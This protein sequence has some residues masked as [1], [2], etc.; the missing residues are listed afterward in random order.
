MTPPWTRSSPVSGDAS[1]SSGLGRAACRISGDAATARRRPQGVA[2]RRQEIEHLIAMMN[3]VPRLSSTE[4]A[5]SSPPGA[6]AAP[7]AG[8]SADWRSSCPG[9]SSSWR[10]PRCSSAA[11]P[12]RHRAAGVG[13][14]ARR[15]RRRGPRRRQAW[16]SPLGV[17]G[18][19]QAPGAS[20]DRLRR[21]GRRRDGAGRRPGSCSSCSHAA[22]S[23]W[24]GPA[25]LRGLAA[26]ARPVVLA[27]ASVTRGLLALCWTALKVGALSYGGGFG[28]DPARRAGGR[29]PTATPDDALESLN[30]VALGQGHA[31]PRRAH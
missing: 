26:H 12:R 10:S 18:G 20:A 11:P 17:G 25:R 30:A 27:G 4:L 2:R 16:N 29:G 23:S 3:L 31:R 1:A 28:D 6:C 13:A 7:P 15:R 19:P 8:S 21:R 24:R 5:H 14:G 22:R 9:S